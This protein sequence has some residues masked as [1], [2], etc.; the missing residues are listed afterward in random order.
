MFYGQSKKLDISILLTYVAKQNII[1][2]QGLWLV[3]VYVSALVAY[4]TPSC[5]M[6]S[7]GLNVLY[8]GTS[9]TG[10]CSVSCEGVVFHS[11]SLSPV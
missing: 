2:D 10:L 5:T 1:I 6:M 8:V 3:G 11:V 9:L 7:V 4:K